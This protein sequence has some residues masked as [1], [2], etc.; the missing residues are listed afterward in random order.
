VH[1]GIPARLHLFNGTICRAF[2]RKLRRGVRLQAIE[3]GADVA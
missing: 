1:A 3:V 2:G